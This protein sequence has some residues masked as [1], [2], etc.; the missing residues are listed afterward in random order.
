MEHHPQFEE[1]LYRATLADVFARR[2]PATARR[3]LSLDGDRV[4]VEGYWLQLALSERYEGHTQ[5]GP[6]ESWRDRY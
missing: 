5:K 6:G 1:L 3:V 2:A 4:T